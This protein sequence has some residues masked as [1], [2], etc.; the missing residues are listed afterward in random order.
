[1][2]VQLLFP[3]FFLPLNWHCQFTKWPARRTHR[4][5]HT[6]LRCTAVV[7]V[8]SGNISSPFP[9]LPPHVAIGFPFVV[10]NV[11]IQTHWLDQVDEIQWV[12]VCVW[13]T[14]VYTHTQTARKLCRLTH[15]HCLKCYSRE[16]L[17]PCRSTVALVPSATALLLLFPFARITARRWTD[18]NVWLTSAAFNDRCHLLL[19]P[20]SAIYNSPEFE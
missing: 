6:A 17:I 4:Q 5:A 3:S 18:V 16:L 10:V 14:L 15:T 13:C 20:V 1:M 9:L 19:L 8:F 2:S 12:C 7:F 11:L